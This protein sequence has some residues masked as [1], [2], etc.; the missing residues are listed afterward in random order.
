M[1][2][3]PSENLTVRQPSRRWLERFANTLNTSRVI[4]KRAVLLGKRRGWKNCG[5]LGQHR[6]EPKIVR[7]KQVHP[8]QDRGQTAGINHIQQVIATKIQAF[9]LAGFARAVQSSQA[10]I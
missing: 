7:N 4:G 5:S 8:S 3:Y 10:V 6:P 9:D 2:Q 1:I